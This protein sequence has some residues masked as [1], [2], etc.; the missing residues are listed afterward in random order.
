MKRE[1]DPGAVSLGSLKFFLDIGNTHPIVLQKQTSYL[2][3]FEKTSL[4]LSHL[5]N[6]ID[7]YFYMCYH[8]NVRRDTNEKLFFKGSN[9]NAKSGWMV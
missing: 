4:L 6:F 1:R 5:I 3:R 7:T 8:N 9:Q 2:C